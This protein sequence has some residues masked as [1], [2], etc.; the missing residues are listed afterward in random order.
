MIIGKAAHTSIQATVRD[1]CNAHTECTYWFDNRK[2]TRMNRNSGFCIDDFLR[3]HNLS[4]IPVQVNSYV[5]EPLERFVSGIA[6]A[7]FY[8]RNHSVEHYMKKLQANTTDRHFGLQMINAFPT[9]RAGDFYNVSVMNSSCIQ[10]RY[11]KND[12]RF[13]SPKPNFDITK[14]Q[15]KR[16]QHLLRYDY[17]CLAQK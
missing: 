2:W 13:G 11:H 6:E 9:N 5:R 10:K 12:R 4:S 16:I 15:Q 14:A 1:A 8:E 7:W 3:E 17:E